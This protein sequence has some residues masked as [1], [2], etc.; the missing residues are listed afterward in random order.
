M[1]QDLITSVSNREIAA[2]KVRLAQVE[3]CHDLGKKLI[4]LDDLS[5]DLKEQHSALLRKRDGSPAALGL[6][7]TQLLG[8]MFGGG[9]AGWAMGTAITKVAALLSVVNT[10]IAIPAVLIV[11]S[12]AAVGSFR[13]VEKIAPD[14][15]KADFQKNKA[16]YTTLSESRIKAESLMAETLKNDLDAFSASKEFDTLYE[17]FPSLKDRFVKESFKRSRDAVKVLPSLLTAPIEKRSSFNI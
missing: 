11:G 13:L 7:A 2:I 14:I 5:K 3:A 12:I 10:G 8:F 1:K 9:A 17:R 16:L 15:D 6:L 4:L